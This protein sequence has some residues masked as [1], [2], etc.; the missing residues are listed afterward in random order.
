MLNVKCNFKFGKVNLK[1]RFGCDKDETQNHWYD[2]PAINDVIRSSYS[3]ND[4]FSNDPI[5]VKSV[6]KVLMERLESQN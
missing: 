3:Y 4:L 6:T 1:C 2:C 5:K